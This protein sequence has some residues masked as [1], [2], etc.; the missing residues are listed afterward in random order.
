[1]QYY[2][3]RYSSSGIEVSSNRFGV[4]VRNRVPL[5]HRFQIAGSMVTCAFTTIEFTSPDIWRVLTLIC[6]SPDTFCFAHD[7]RSQG[8]LGNPVCTW[9]MQR[10]CV[11]YICI[12][13]KVPYFHIFAARAGVDR[14]GWTS[15]VEMSWST[16]SIAALIVACDLLLLGRSSIHDFFQPRSP[17]I[18]LLW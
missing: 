15:L 3:S 14:R 7:K 12:T 9:P 13:S 4:K 5:A 8:A 18:L 2:S 1:M 6:S 16:Q 17:E 11:I 10:P